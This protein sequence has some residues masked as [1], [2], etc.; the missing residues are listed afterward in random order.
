MTSP[1]NH[2]PGCLGKIGYPTRAEA[3]QA[4]SRLR[5][6]ADYRADGGMAAYKCVRCP[7]FHLG[8]DKRR[9]VKD[10]RRTP[11]HEAGSYKARKARYVELTK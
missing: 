5:Q 11:D 4:K 9:G 6:K 2:G 7:M 1:R 10:L 8:R 3:D